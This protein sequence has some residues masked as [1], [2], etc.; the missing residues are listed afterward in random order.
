MRPRY[1]YGNDWPQKYLTWRKKN[2]QPIAH[3]LENDGPLTITIPQAET[4]RFK[5]YLTGSTLES[6]RLTEE[7]VFEIGDTSKATTNSF[8]SFPGFRLIGKDRLI[9][10]NI[11]I[12]DIVGNAISEIANC[13]LEAS[14]TLIAIGDFENTLGCDCYEILYKYKFSPFYNDYDSF[15]APEYD[16]AI[17]YKAASHV[18]SKDTSQIGQA[19]VLEYEAKCT[20]ILTNRANDGEASDEKSIQFGKNRFFDIQGWGYPTGFSS[21][22][23]T[24]IW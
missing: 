2:K 9:S 15:P 11:T 18:W 8:T 3:D 22:I 21:D 13:E 19:K 17:I 10:N 23:P 6:D 20:A 4:T 16:D 12:T 14:F 1:F 24:R 5:V 7:V